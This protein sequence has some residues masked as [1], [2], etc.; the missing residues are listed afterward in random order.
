MGWFPR[1]S[2]RVVEF[3]GRRARVMMEIEL[4]QQYLDD[5]AAAAAWLKRWGLV[6]TR[7]AHGN[8]VSMAVRGVTLDLLA[9]V[10][11]QLS[12]ALPTLSDPDMALNNL[13]RFVEAARNP[14]SLAALFERD[15]EALPTL[16]QIFSTSQYLSD[17]LI[18]DKESYDLLRMTEGASLARR[19][20][21]ADLVRE[22]ELLTDDKLT[23]AALR[24]FKHRETLRVAYGDI[25]RNLPLETVT[26]QISYV[27]T[28]W[29]KPRCNQA[30]IKFRHPASARLDG[31][32]VVVVAGKLGGEEL[33]YSSDINASVVLRPDGKTNGA[34][35]Q[36]IKSFSSA[37][38]TR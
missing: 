9:T 35:S 14:L 18:R 25:V 34:K 4:L 11:D 24:R 29:S 6:D 10:C 33:N 12:S 30:R 17:H 8:L 36:A 5:P 13:D 28:P 3:G 37:W 19:E 16:L 31:P 2:F 7:R 23:L 32:R 27:V 20:L 38:A 22:V 21:V 1:A 26:R 15:P